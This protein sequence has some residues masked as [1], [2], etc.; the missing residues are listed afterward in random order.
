MILN[1]YNV[2]IHRDCYKGI[3]GAIERGDLRRTSESRSGA[4]G[5]Q[6]WQPTKLQPQ[7]ALSD[8][9]LRLGQLRIHAPIYRLPSAE[10][11]ALLHASAGNYRGY[12]SLEVLTDSMLTMTD[13]DEF[14]HQ[15]SDVLDEGESHIAVPSSQADWLP[16]E[17]RLVE[18]QRDWLLNLSFIRRSHTR[19]RSRR[20]P[21]GVDVGLNPLATAVVGNM[22]LQTPE[23]PLVLLPDSHDPAGFQ[24]CEVINYRL[25]RGVLEEMTEQLIQHASSVAVEQL[26]FRTFAP[27]FVGRGRG[28]AIIDWHQAWLPQTMMATGIPLVRVRPA[29][30]SVRCSRCSS[31]DTRRDRDRLTCWH[32][33]LDIDVHENAAKNILRRARGERYRRRS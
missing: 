6:V 22:I 30:T 31:Q 3:S 13:P 17:T 15:L 10:H 26:D 27:R 32:C 29:Y 8:H 11:Q 23:L 25:S 7:V 33:G 12:A 18:Q 9:L 16:D 21:A 1:T 20:Q 4:G 2:R 19:P 5:G 14:V 24:L 28:A